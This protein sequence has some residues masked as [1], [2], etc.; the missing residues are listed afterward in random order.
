[1]AL[2]K[3]LKL[4]DFRNFEERTFSFDAS[5]VVF[6]GK[7]GSGKAIFLRRSVI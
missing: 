2:I 1:M 7:N 6:T 5:D 4:R 3:E